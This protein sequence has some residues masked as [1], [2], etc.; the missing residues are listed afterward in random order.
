MEKV[1]IIVWESKLPL[2]F[3]FDENDI[4]PTKKMAEKE[5]LLYSDDNVYTVKEVDEVFIYLYAYLRNT[6]DL[7]TFT[8][9]KEDLEKVY[10]FFENVTDEELVKEYLAQL[11]TYNE[12]GIYIFDRIEFINK[13]IKSLEC[14]KK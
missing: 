3:D 1:Y 14:F 6:T 7:T 5:L 4:F 13:K 8:D 11:M 12:E 10:D 2:G 9:D